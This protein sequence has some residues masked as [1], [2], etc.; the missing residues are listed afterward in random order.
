MNTRSQLGKLVGEWSGT[1]RL[2]LTPTDPARESKTS[3]TIALAA[4]TGFVT[5]NYKWEYDG[6]PQDGLL[7]VR[8]A[9]EPSPEDMS[10]IDSFHTGGKFMMFRG[11]EDREGRIAALTSYA[12]PPGPDWGWRIVVE[13]ENA[14][15]VRII[16]Y[17]I[18]PDGDE[19]LA[20]EIDCSRA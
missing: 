2:W 3:G 16:M 18:T 6:K 9:A 13:A 19:A 11:E 17:N 12:A 4:G 10:W 8:N 20:V 7:I 14:D 1:N 5:I 15:R